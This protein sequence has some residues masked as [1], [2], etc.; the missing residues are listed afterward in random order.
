MKYSNVNNLDDCIVRALTFDEYSNEG[1]DYSATTLIKS[2]QQV[3]L[4]KENDNA[5][6]QDVGDLVWARFGTAI[7]DWLYRANQNEKDLIC[8]K[9]HTIAVKGKTVSGATDAYHTIKHEVIDYKTTSVYAVKD[10]KVKP[11]WE[12]Q[13]NIY[14]YMWRANGYSVRSLKI[15]A[16]LR[17][18]NQSGLLRGGSYPKT[19]IVSLD[20]PL[21][22]EQQQL[23]YI[24]QRVDVH[25]KAEVEYEMLGTLPQC[26][27][28]ERWQQ[29]DKWAL[30]TKG[31]K[32]AL[33]LYSKEE[34]AEKA[35]AKSTNN[36]IEHREGKANR[37]ERYCPCNQFCSQYQNK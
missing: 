16:V 31:K 14:A 18:W 32:R 23:D 4:Q 30:M 35:L 10:G 6:V 15:I 27:E 37:C 19:P 17:D 25:K 24:T 36:Y 9:R 13:L 34:D 3:I 20:V 7:H 26:S 22:S 11:E 1:S 21:W 8:E 12:K 2:P 5:I 29:P 28:E 33:K